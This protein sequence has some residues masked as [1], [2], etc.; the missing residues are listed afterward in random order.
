MRVFVATLLG[1]MGTATASSEEFMDD[2]GAAAR[3]L[4]TS[5]SAGMRIKSDSA[6]LAFGTDGDVSITRNGAASLTINGDLSVDGSLK[7][8]GTSFSTL[9]S[10][11]TTLE[12]TVNTVSTTATTNTNTLTTSLTALTTRV[13]TAETDIN[14]VEADLSTKYT[15]QNSDITSLKTRMTD[16]ED[17]VTNVALRERVTEAENDVA[18]LAKAENCN[19]AECCGF[20]YAWVSNTLYCWSSLYSTFT[21]DPCACKGVV[22]DLGSSTANANE[23]NCLDQGAHLMSV[24]S[25][26][27]NNALKAYGS[28]MYIGSFVRVCARSVVH[29]PLSIVHVYSVLLWSASSARQGDVPIATWLMTR[30]DPAR[31]T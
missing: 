23:K 1:L 26:T 20:N 15:S 19:R 3:Q 25:A 9:S 27:A 12:T 5:G 30:V 11:V 22:Q 28:T 6:T 31:A 2:Q 18:A 10:K 8:A 16:A 14:N 7:V 17:D 24:T 4:A 29:R 21:D 13:T